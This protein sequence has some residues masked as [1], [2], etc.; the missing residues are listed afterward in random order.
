MIPPILPPNISVPQ[1]PPDP[2]KSE[3]IA[4]D[5]Q[6]RVIDV[7]VFRKILVEFELDRGKGRYLDL[8]V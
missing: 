7:R 2:K 4:R 1:D 3:K 6:G 8:R 5:A